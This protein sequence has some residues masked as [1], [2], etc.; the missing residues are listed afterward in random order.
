MK[1]P[2]DSIFYLSDY[3]KSSILVTHCACDSG[4]NRHSYTLLLRISRCSREESGNSYQ[5]Y[6]FMYTF[7][8]QIHL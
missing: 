6:Q 8:Q 4:G 7:D 3:Q 1:L 5:N 2:W